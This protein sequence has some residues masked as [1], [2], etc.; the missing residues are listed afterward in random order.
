MLAPRAQRIYEN[1][2][3]L[4]VQGAENV[5]RAAVDAL[6][7]HAQA[8]KA[9]KREL[10][11]ADLAFGV[12][13]LWASRPT[14][15]ALR[16]A[17]RYVYVRAR[18]SPSTS[19]SALKNLVQKEARGYRERTDQV[20]KK[21]GTYGARLVPEDARVLVHCHSSTVMRV[22]KQA[23]DDGK[24][25]HVFCTESRP[26]YQG[27]LTAKELSGYGLKVTMFV[28]GASHLVLS[29]MRDTDLVLV[30]ADAVTSEGDLVNKVGTAMV[31]HAAYDHEK[32]FYSCTAT[33][34]FDPLTLFGWPEP[35]EER[36]AAEVASPKEFPKVDLFNP[37]FDLTPAKL[38]TAYVTEIG[39]LPPQGLVGRV[40]DQLG[41]GEEQEV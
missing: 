2:K 10:F 20:K 31:A 28:D 7:I 40:W 22:L 12:K 38:V 19:V 24:K 1:I 16:N 15:P 41:L 26:L 21:I 9:V 30:G 34:K 18:A 11:L 27:H 29:Q 3:A 33:H 36:P 23:H 32:R 35:I 13:H 5:A 39:V 8:S 14:E 37:A 25:P 17:L 4:R 6:A